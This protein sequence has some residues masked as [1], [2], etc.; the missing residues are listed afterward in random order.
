MIYNNKIYSNKF[1]NIITEILGDYKE[2]EKIS[3]S[4]KN[5]Y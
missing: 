1:I 4:E 3:K 2:F 5:V